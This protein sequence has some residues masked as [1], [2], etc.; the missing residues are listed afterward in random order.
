MITCHRKFLAARCRQR[1]YTLDEVRPCIVS[2]DGDQITVDETHPAYPRVPK[3]VQAKSVPQDGPGSELKSLL[4]KFG[5]HASPTCKCNAMAGKM[6]V[7]ESKEPGWCLSHIEEIVDV[8][9]ETAKARKLPFLR[10]AG[11][12]LVKK[13]V[14]NW[15]KKATGK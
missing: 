5:I 12:L 8:M 1:G 15:Q 13:A 6:N 3:T 11:R 9:E 14:K 10:T 4:A 2:E 7:M